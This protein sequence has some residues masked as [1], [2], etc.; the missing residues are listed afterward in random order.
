MTDLPGGMFL[1]SS[2]TYASTD[3]DLSITDSTTVID[4][5]IVANNQPP[6]PVGESLTLVK[7]GDGEFVLSG[8]NAQQLLMEYFEKAPELWLRLLAVK[9]EKEESEKNDG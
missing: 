5:T 2:N 8:Q 9:A 6:P 4:S 7:T 1:N 3:C